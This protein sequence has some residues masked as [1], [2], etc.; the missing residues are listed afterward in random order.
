MMLGFFRSWTL[1][2][3]WISLSTSLVDS[4]LQGVIG[5]CAV[6]VLCNLLRMHL[7]I[8]CLNGPSHLRRE[9]SKLRA[10]S[11]LLEFL[12]LVIMSGLF[13]V[14]GARVSSLV[15]LE[16][17]LRTVSM[18][19][20]AKQEAC[21]AQAF[22]LC[23]YSLGCGMTASL[24]YLNESAPH[25][26]CSLALSTGLA[27]LLAWSL[28]K[29]VRHVTTMYQLHSTERYCGACLSLLTTWHQVP[30]L[31]GHAMKIAFAVADVAAIFLINRDFLTASEA[32]RF[33]TP[34][35]ICY[36]L[37]V[38]Y[39]QE[40]QK[41]K[42]SEQSCIQTVCVRMGGLLILTLTVGRW[43]DVLHVLLSLL[44]ELWCLIR[45]ANMLE[46]CRLQ[47]AIELQG[48]GGTRQLSTERRSR[49]SNTPKP[50]ALG[51]SD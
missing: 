11:Q 41:Q 30:A 14:V 16:F 31:L 9:A 24:S 32:L 48:R 22:L 3:G 4:L 17:S 39:M 1:G 46:V 12:H 35:T 13:S 42:S 10:Q 33:W 28:E 25:S 19:L 43:V 51:D 5:A 2:F 23:Q 49:V 36:T 26:T 20:S 34:L 45:V 27:G 18:L 38:I 37:L 44:G 21:G 15:V 40:E 29:L 50:G 6:C 8:L 47:E 7:Y